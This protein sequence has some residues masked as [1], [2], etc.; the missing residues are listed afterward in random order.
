MTT[1]TQVNTYL[2]YIFQEFSR[3]GDK[4]ATMHQTGN[5]PSFDKEVKLALLSAY[6]TIADI[7]LEQ[8]D[9]PYDNNLMTVAEFEDVMRHINRICNS[10]WWL[11]LSE[12]LPHIEI[13]VSDAT[14][15]ELSLTSGDNEVI[16]NWGDGSG[17]ELSTG[18]A[19]PSHVYSG[20][21]TAKLYNPENVISFTCDNNTNVSAV[22]I[23]AEAVNLT[24]VGLNSTNISEFITYDTWTSL[25]QFYINDTNITSLIVYREW[26]TSAIIF[27]ATDNDITDATIINNI[28]I[29][30]DATG[31]NTFFISLA[32]G[33]NAAPTGAGATAKSNLQGRGVNVITN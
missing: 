28:L 1:Q 30:L 3:Y 4:L 27:G 29:E 25:L 6:I 9:D 10:H 32:G 24:V 5:K 21:A 33:T 2:G 23:P 26:F 8:W 11:D 22:V 20:E 16:I 31:L 12:E 14:T 17:M 15:L 13:T 19:T 18:T 7:Y